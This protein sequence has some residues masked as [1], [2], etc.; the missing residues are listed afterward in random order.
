VPSF[1]VLA[2]IVGYHLR[3]HRPRP[4]RWPSGSIE[5][6]EIAASFNRASSSYASSSR[7]VV[8]RFP[9]TFFHASRTHRH[10][11]AVFVCQ[12]MVSAL[13]SRSRKDVTGITTC[14][15]LTLPRKWGLRV[16][17]SLHRRRSR[18]AVDR[19]DGCSHSILL[20]VE[21]YQW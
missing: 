7:V 1:D 18:S 4:K 9:E 11:I 21:G 16:L 2:V 3:S 10:N 6:F 19:K 17:T 8:C 13:P 15:G 12:R 5:V 20:S 14:F